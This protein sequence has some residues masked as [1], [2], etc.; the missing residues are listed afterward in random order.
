MKIK[1][2]HH[3]KSHLKGVNVWKVST[4][5]L[6]LA[7]IV[8]GTIMIKESMSKISPKNAT[9]KAIEYINKYMITAKGTVSSIDKGTTPFYKFTIDIGGTKYPS[10]VS[11]DGTKLIPYDSYDITKA[12]GT[13]ASGS[14]ATSG[15]TMAAKDSTDVEGG[16]KSIND[17]NVCTENGKPIVYFFGSEGCPHCKWEKPIIEAIIKEFGTAISFHE[18]IDSSTDQDVFTQYST[19]SIPTLVIGCKYWRIGSGESAG[20]TSEKESLTKVICRATGNLPA[21]VCQ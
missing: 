17:V 1:G 16:F 18:N 15:A 5:V 10:Y 4:I 2:L 8:L 19:G 7:V 12:A 20:E 14:S 6:A 11:A 13:A 9:A 21:S 3:L